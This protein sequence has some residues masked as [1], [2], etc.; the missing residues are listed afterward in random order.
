MVCSSNSERLGPGVGVGVGPGS[1]QHDV[2]DQPEADRDGR[3]PITAREPSR[4][5]DG[6]GKPRYGRFRAITIR[7]TWFVPS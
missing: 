6:L 1:P 3:K 2:H 5:A 4:T 7:C